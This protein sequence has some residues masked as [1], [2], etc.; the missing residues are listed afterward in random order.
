VI[1]LDTT[2]QERFERDLRGNARKHIGR[3]GQSAAIRSFRRMMR[4]LAD[5]ATDLVSPELRALRSDLRQLLIGWLK[6]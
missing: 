3:R 2:P 1:D 5:E 4:T 6:P